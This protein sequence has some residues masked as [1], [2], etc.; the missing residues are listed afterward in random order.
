MP[1]RK[2]KPPPRAAIVSPFSENRKTGP[3]AVTWVSQASCS[4]LCPFLGKGCYGESGPVAIIGMRLDEGAVGLT[5]EQIACQEADAID[6]TPAYADK[7]LHGLGDSR[8]PAAATIVAAAA[9]RYKAR[10]RDEVDVWTYTHSF[11]NVPRECWG[12][13]SVLA[14]VEA[15]GQL[16]DAWTRGYAAAMVVE[17]Y[18]S[19]SAYRLE[20]EEGRTWVG[21][22][23]LYQTRK[24]Q[25]I[26]CRLCMDD[27]KLHAERRVILFKAHGS[28][29]TT[30]V[31]TLR[32]LTGEA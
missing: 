7:R 28:R 23:C 26:D 21:V 12:T 4:T 1:K 16:H 18:E 2:R 31:R 19:T 29:R 30:V 10:A 22:P 25:C 6:R 27:R 20:D 17:E 15:V 14:S 3:V 32:V 11:E 8:T 13:V 24:I 5:P 9:M